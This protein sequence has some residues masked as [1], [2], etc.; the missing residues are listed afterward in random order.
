ML[1]QPQH[2]PPVLLLQLL[3][4]LLLPP[5]GLFLHHE[6]RVLLGVKSH[7]VLDVFVDVLERP[8]SLNN[9][10]SVLIWVVKALILLLGIG[11]L[12]HTT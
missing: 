4:Q 7:L 1:G 9:F 5:D 8:S 12:K 3:D 2:P 10:E 6:V 11:K